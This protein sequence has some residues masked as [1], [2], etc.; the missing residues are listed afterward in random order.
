MIDQIY[1]QHDKLLQQNIDVKVLA[2]TTIDGMNLSEDG[3]DLSNWRND[4]KK[5]MYKFGPENVDDIIKFVKEKK[6]LNPVFVDC[7]ASY[8]L[9][10]RYLDILNAGMSIATP[11]K[12]AN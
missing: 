3:L 6:P 7:T 4:M 2:I 9:P 11:N 12:R 10:D 8:D 5:P 1:Q